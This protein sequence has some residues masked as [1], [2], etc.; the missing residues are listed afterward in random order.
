VELV[1]AHVAKADLLDIWLYIAEDN[2]VAADGV[3]DQIEYT[4]NLLTTQ[5]KM[6]RVRAELQTGVRSFPCK[7]P[8]T[9]YY[10][11]TDTQLLVTRVLHQSRDVTRLF[12]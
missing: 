6:G 3:I 12:D 9:I 2:P 7:P 1:F 4:A 10:K 11:L 5:P 8:Y